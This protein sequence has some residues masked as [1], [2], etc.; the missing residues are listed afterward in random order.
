ML[1]APEYLMCYILLLSLL[2]F[3]EVVV[4]PSRFTFVKLVEKAKIG[5]SSVHVGE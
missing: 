3:D 1:I 4:C 2:S 5:Y